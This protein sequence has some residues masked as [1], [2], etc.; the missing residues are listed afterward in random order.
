MNKRSIIFTVLVM[1]SVCRIAQ[2]P[3]SIERAQL[4]L[5]V[6]IFGWGIPVYL[7][8]DYGVHSDIS[9]GGEFSCR[10]YDENWEMNYSI[11]NVM[12]FSGNANHQLIRLLKIPQK[13]N[14]YVGLNLPQFAWSSTINHFANINSGVGIGAQIVGRYYTEDKLA[15]N[16]EF[17]ETKFLEETNSSLKIYYS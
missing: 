7:V 11:H 2:S 14:V 6:E 13:W 10:S 12:G 1:L 8:P 4:N 9:I 16:I 5:H 17:G 3:L 15:F